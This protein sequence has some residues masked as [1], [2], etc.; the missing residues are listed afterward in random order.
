MK[1]IET[2]KSTDHVPVRHPLGGFDVITGTKAF[3]SSYKTRKKG[4]QWYCL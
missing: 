1:G 2:R 3:I 4:Q